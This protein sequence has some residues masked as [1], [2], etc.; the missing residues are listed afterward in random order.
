MSQPITPDIPGSLAR[1]FIVSVVIGTV[2]DSY[3]AISHHTLLPTFTMLV[4]LPLW[5]S[6]E[7]VRWTYKRAFYAR[8]LGLI[9]SPLG[10]PPL[11]EA[12]TG[13]L[14]GLQLAAERALVTLLPTIDV[15]RVPALSPRAHAAALRL[16]NRQ[17]KPMQLAMLDL[18]EVRGDG[19]AWQPVASLARRCRNE[20]VR[21]RAQEVLPLL[22][23]R[24]A[25]AQSVALL[26]RASSA[27]TS[28]N[29]LLRAGQ[30]VI[31]SP[32]ELL[33]AA[34]SGDSTRRGE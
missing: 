17:S 28:A 27:D 2:I 6:F 20:R 22:E 8:M 16:L 31:E 15:T 23:A 33:R 34:E 32:L 4:T 19:S 29:T 25:E 9:R 12:I 18:L 5:L 11:L 14:P 26:L 3:I 24:R 10:V 21:E 30:T 7:T 1:L 13:Q